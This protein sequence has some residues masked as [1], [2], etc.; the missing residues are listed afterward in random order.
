M[1][2]T[3]PRSATQEQWEDLVAKIKGIHGVVELTTNDCNYPTTGEK[4]SVALWLLPAGVYSNSN[5]VSVSTS[6]TTTSTAKRLYI[7]CPSSTES[8]TEYTQ[9]VQIQPT[10][11]NGVPV[12]LN[13]TITQN[14]DSSVSRSVLYQEDIVNTLTSTSTMR[15]LSAN[16]GRVL[17]EKIPVITMTTTDPGEGSALADNNYIGVY[18]GDPIIVDYSTAEINTGAKWIDGRAIYKKTVDIGTLPNATTKEVAHGITNLANVIKFEGWTYNSA[19]YFPLPYVS[20]TA[21]N[22]MA[23]MVRGANIRIIT[24]ID[25]S[26]YTTSYVT[27]Y[28][29]KSS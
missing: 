17:N 18:D 25:R 13:Q 10:A 28:Y 23:V 3:D 5:G 22:S 7:V 26:D 8:G 1:A 9:I 19:Q 4:T 15:P 11:A 20:T 14:G 24:G 21:V 16:Q 6:N 2:N 27:L 29:T 12:V